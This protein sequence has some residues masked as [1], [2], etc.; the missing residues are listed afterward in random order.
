[1]DIYISKRFK[2]LASLKHQKKVTITHR[3]IVYITGEKMTP[4]P[5]Y[6]TQVA[7]G[8]SLVL[9]LVTKFSGNH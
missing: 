9:L 6:D 4:S 1:M 8:I 3:K 5:T 7:R 2:I